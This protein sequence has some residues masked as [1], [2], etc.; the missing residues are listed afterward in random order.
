MRRREFITLLGGCT[1]ALWPLSACTQQTEKGH[2]LLSRMLRMHADNAAVIVRQFITGIESQLGWTV[3]LP[4]SSGSIEQRRFDALRLLRQVPAVTEVA[5]IDA[6]GKERLRVSRLTAD[7]VGGGTDLSQE[8]KFTEALA[9]KVYYGPVDFRESGPANAR[10][11]EPYMTLSV[12][13]TRPDAG[14]SIAEVN[15]QLMWDVVSQIKVGQR[16][17]AYVLDANGHLISHSD[18]VM[19]LRKT[20][21]TVLAHVQAARAG[22]PGTTNAA[23]QITKNSQGHEVLTS[24]TEVAPFGWLI[25]LELPLEEAKSLAQ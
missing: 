22:G 24:Y 10:I 12:G 21:M 13:S 11:S 16:G 7:V 15:L 9:K 19:V 5:M 2:V 6:T 25:F 4:W 18:I 17:S 23:G 20:D 8:P 3:Q 14:V 1:A